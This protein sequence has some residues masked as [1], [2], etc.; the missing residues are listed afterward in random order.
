MGSSSAAFDDTALRAGIAAYARK[1]EAAVVQLGQEIA[2][3]LE[4]H[5]KQHAPWEDRTGD[6]REGL[7]ATSELAG[8]LVM[9]YLSHGPEV[10]Y[11]IHLE[12]AHGAK[13]AIIWPTIE[14]FLP[15]IKR[16]IEELLR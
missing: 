3:E 8:S 12:L 4:R 10:N 9:I 13:F 7:F 6:A 2:E 1:V 16:R 5:A 15:T 11:G 14:T